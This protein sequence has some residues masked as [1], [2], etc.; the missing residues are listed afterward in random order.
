MIVAAL[1]WIV[2]IVTLM[3][4]ALCVFARNLFHAAL[5]L[6]ICLLGVAGLYLF[7]QA[8]YLAAI[9]LVV[10]VGGVL[11][12]AVFGVMASRDI[13]GETQRS[14][15]RIWIIGLGTGTLVLT[16]LVRVVMTV[17]QHAPGLQMLRSDPAT[18]VQ[19][20]LGDALSSAWLLPMVLV[21]VLLVVVLI[22]SLALVRS[23]A[24]EQ[25]GAQ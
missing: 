7:L 13:L 21:P 14:G 5:G 4:A 12:L 3:G 9:Q 19:P 8:E 2:C 10:Y 18:M 15:V 24:D 23:D 16:A 6:G 17:C 11:V 20:N 1:F 25:E 22:G